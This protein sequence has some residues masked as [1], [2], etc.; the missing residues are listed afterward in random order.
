MSRFSRRRLV[1]RA[2]AGAVA[3]AALGS[4]TPPIDQ[5]WV[6]VT[7]PSLEVAAGSALDFSA[8]TPALPEARATIVG[9]QLVFAGAARPINCALLGPGFSPTPGRSFPDHDAAR[10]YAIQL[11]RHGYNLVR[12]HFTDALLMRGARADFA[13]NPEELDR[14]HF[15]QAQLREQGI[16]WLVDVLASSNAALGN[17]FPHRWAADNGMAWRPFVEDAALDHWRTLAERLLTTRNPYTG[18]TLASDP[19]TAGLVLVNEPNLDFRMAWANKFR[20]GPMPKLMRDAYLRSVPGALLP[21]TSVEVGPA[22]EGVQRFFTERQ[23]VTFTKMATAVRTLNYSGSLTSFD[24]WSRY[25]QLPTLRDLP[26]IAMHGYEADQVASGVAP[27]TRVRPSS[28]FE[29]GARYLQLMASMRFHG[30]PLL[31]TEHDQIFWNP[32]RFEAGLVAPAFA[33]LQGWSTLCRHADG[34]I[35]LAYDGKGLRKQA[36]EPDGVGLD[37]VARAGE[38]LTALLWLRREIAPAPGAVRF[39]ITDAEAL[40][41]GGRRQLPADL[42]MLGW[43]ARIGI[44]DAPGAGVDQSLAADSAHDTRPPDR[45]DRTATLLAALRRAGALPPRDATDPATGR[46]DAPGGQVSLRLAERQLRV[47]TRFTAALASGPVAAPVT[48]GPVRFLRSDAPALAAFSALDGRPLA[49][50]GRILAI[51]ASDARNTGMRVAPNGRLEAL[52]GLPAQLRSVRMT[53]AL[54]LLAG[55]GWRIAPLS[56]SGVKGRSHLLRYKSGTLILDLSTTME[57]TR[58]TVYFLLEKD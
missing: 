15:F 31:A 49:R 18:T 55:R 27:G 56:L 39:R 57:R 10:R 22:M 40:R 58:P 13:F 35:D 1:R 19:H 36:I 46:W 6:T 23:R 4:G 17:I 33:A 30:R 47:A 21:S 11:R 41:D 24:T 7:D 52:G 38:T 42:G 29:N 34:P 45:S 25:N 20:P 3:F 54:R 2:L 8:L 28:S 12:F 16:H 5:E 43:V 50:S 9:E 14:F 48:I 37:P 32:N 53:V 44:G 51:L 26:L